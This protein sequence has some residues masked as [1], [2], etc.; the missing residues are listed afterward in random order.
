ML[1]HDRSFMDAHFDDIVDFAELREFID[2]PVKNFSSGMVT[3]LG[4]AI[5]T[6]VTADLLVVDEVLA[7]GDFMFQQKCLKRL[8]RMLSGGTTLLFV[9]HSTP[10]VCELCD[11]AIWLDHGVKRGDGP[12]REVC[13]EYED[14]MRRGEA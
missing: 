1:G 4:F 7:V 5:A 12:V 8:D 3:R 9:S 13:D 14:A 2:V 11:R 6:E 10:Q